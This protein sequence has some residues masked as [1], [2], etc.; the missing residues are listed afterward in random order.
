MTLEQIIRY[1]ITGIV[2]QG[3]ETENLNEDIQELVDILIDFSNV[4]DKSLIDI[5][6]NATM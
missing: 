3:D 2:L 1:A 5:L 6:N 4:T